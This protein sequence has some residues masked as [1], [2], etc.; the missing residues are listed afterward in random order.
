MSSSYQGGGMRYSRLALIAIGALFFGGM[1][2]TKANWDRV[3]WG[4][5]VPEAQKAYPGARFGGAALAVDQGA[6]TGSSALATLIEPDS[7][8]VVHFDYQPSYGEFRAD[9][10]EFAVLG[11]FNDVAQKIKAKYG[12]PVFGAED[13]SACFDRDG[14]RIATDPSGVGHMLK[15]CEGSAIFVDRPAGNAIYLGRDAP[16]DVFRKTPGLNPSQWYQTVRIGD[17]R[18]CT[19]CGGS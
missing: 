6:I 18:A 10:V 11:E 17:I 2:M 15:V 13:D 9:Y 1:A 16:H 4:M 3:H 5:T 14:N 19:E 7:W 8:V 12:K